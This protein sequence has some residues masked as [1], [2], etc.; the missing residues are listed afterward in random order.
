VRNSSK[1]KRRLEPTKSSG[2]GRTADWLWIL[3]SLDPPTISGS[4]DDLWI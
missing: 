3:R 1:L 4:T 2:R